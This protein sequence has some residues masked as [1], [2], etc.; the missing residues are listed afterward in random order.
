MNTENYY[1]SCAYED[2]SNSRE[3][4]INIG[5]RA[6]L[7][8]FYKAQKLNMSKAYPSLFINSL[9]DIYFK[10]SKQSNPISEIYIQ[11]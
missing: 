11:R 5:T 10:K 8:L 6:G 9:I 4:D 3:R 2:I 7:N 1:F